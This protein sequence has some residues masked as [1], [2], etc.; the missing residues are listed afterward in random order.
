MPACPS[1]VLLPGAAAVLHTARSPS[2]RGT[3]APLVH[4]TGSAASPGFRFE[5]TPPPPAHDPAPPKRTDARSAGVRTAAC[6]SSLAA[7][8]SPTPLLPKPFSAL[9]LSPL[10]PPHSWPTAPASSS[11]RVLPL[12]LFLLHRS[13]PPPHAHSSRS[14]RRRSLP[15][16]ASSFPRFPIAGCS[17][18]H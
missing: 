15:P 16:T 18:S 9:L 12:S 4:E 3:R 17:C 14:S 7:V 6:N 11:D 5:G 2:L 8:R 10:T 13:F 1:A